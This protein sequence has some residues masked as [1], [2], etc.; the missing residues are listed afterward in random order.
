MSCTTAWQEKSSDRNRHRSFLTERYKCPSSFRSTSRVPI[1]LSTENMAIVNSIGQVTSRS[2]FWFIRS[3]DFSDFGSRPVFTFYPVRVIYLQ[4]NV[5]KRAQ[6]KRW[7]ADF[8]SSLLLI[9]T[10]QDAPSELPCDFGG[11][12]A[13]CL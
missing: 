2:D 6:K 7:Q 8:R 3:I 5:A 4:T 10:R 13:A 1:V 9:S 11:I 12:F